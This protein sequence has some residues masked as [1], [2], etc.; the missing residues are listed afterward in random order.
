MPRVR[1]APTRPPLPRGRL[2]S[3][4][5]KPAPITPAQV[6]PVTLLTSGVNSGAG[7]SFATASI[8]PAGNHLILLWVESHPTASPTATGNGLTWVQVDQATDGNSRATV[9]RAMGASPSSGAVTIAFGATSQDTC[10]W[11]IVDYGNVDTSGTNGSGALVQ[12]NHNTATPVTSLTV[13][14]PAGIGA[15]NAVAAAIAHAVNETQ[16]AGAGYTKLGEVSD[17]SEGDWAH[18]WRPD[19]TTTP[20]MSWTTSVDGWGV[21]VEIKFALAAPPLDPEP[22]FHQITQLGGWF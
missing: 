22:T 18:C 3:R 11:L 20:S 12:S 17:N 15:G 4:I 5:L 9:L 1:Q 19:G 14:L 6:G 10:K 8:S 21:A 7:T 13:T 2:G 16:T